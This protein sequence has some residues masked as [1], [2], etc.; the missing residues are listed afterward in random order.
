MG[1][2][3]LVLS[4]PASPLLSAILLG[5]LEGIEL[6]LFLFSVYRESKLDPQPTQPFVAAPT[7]S[8]PFRQERKE[9]KREI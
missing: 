9:M 1:V 3:L 4:T 5:A 8:L 7:A 6:S 2:I